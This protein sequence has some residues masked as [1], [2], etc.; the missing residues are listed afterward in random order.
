MTDTS[1][2]PPPAAGNLDYRVA[3]LA[4]RLAAGDLGELGVRLELRGDA[5]L[6]TGTV[7]SAQCRDEICHTAREELAGHPV[8]CDIL[9]AGTSS[10]D[11]GEDLT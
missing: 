9:V 5:I 6:L 1:P 4:E 7:P 10:P 11:H 3:H 2:P 8:H